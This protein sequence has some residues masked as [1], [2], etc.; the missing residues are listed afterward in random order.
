MGFL[1][2]FF[3]LIVEVCI[4]ILGIN[5]KN[6]KHVKY[7]NVLSAIKPVP[8]GPSIPVPVVTG[9]ISEMECSSSTESE[10]SKKDTWNVEQST[11][12]P[13]HLTQLELNDLTQDVNL[14]KETAQ[15]LGSRLRENNLLAT[16][17]TYFWCRKRD[18]EFTKYFN[19]DKVH[20]GLPTFHHP[21]FN[22]PTLNHGYL[23]TRHLK[24]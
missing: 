2:I 14:T 18:E 7:T 11:N 3:D 21:T 20:S 24:T 6:K 4:F 17:T 9:D 16:S 19:Y 8:H 10:A 23:I 15:L 22:H 13:K 12:Q 5:R 1:F